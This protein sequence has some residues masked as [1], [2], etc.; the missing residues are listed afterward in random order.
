[1]FCRGCRLRTI[2]TS[3][4]AVSSM[5]SASSCS[6]EVAVDGAGQAE[7]L[8]RRNW[9]A[10]PSWRRRSRIVAD[11]DIEHGLRQISRRPDP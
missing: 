10:S 1:M 2:L 8:C 4:C 7:V 5:Y 11:H 3:G 6:F 9:R